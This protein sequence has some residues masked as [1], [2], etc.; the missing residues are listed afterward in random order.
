M[1]DRNDL[2]K[3]FREA[4]VDRSGNLTVTELTV[5]LNKYGYRGTDAEIKV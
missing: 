4:D 5:I 2:E 3:F 1:A